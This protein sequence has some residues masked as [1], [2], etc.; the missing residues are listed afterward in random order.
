MTLDIESLSIN[1]DHNKWWQMVRDVME[2]YPMYDPII[3]HL[4][5]RVMML[6]LTRNGSSKEYTALW[7]WA[8]Y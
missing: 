4:E 1:I 3:E 5:I 8:T 6:C 2:I 7:D